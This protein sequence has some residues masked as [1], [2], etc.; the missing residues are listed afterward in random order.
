[1]V[2]NNYN[3]I[4]PKTLDSIRPKTVWD[5]TKDGAKKVRTYVYIYFKYGCI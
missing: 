5:A 2:G 4:S 3:L 1:M